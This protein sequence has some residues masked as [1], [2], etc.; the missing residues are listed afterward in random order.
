MRKALVAALLVCVWALPAQAGSDDARKKFFVGASMVEVGDLAT[1]IPY[2][3]E[4]LELDS[5]FCRANY[6]LVKCYLDVGDDDSIRKAHDA[7]TAYEGCASDGEQGDVSEL[8]GLL[9]P[10]PASGSSG[11]SGGSSSGDSSPYG[12]DDD[13]GSDRYDDADSGGERIRGE[14][15]ERDTSDDDGGGREERIRGESISRGDDDDD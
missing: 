14:S 4:T 15:L 8:Q 1:A 3:E 2:L 12:D 11:R 10:L 5:S 6:Y 7:A 13:D 9:P